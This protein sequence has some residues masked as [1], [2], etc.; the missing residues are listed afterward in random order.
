MNNRDNLLRQLDAFCTFM[1]CTPND[2]IVLTG[3]ALCLDNI[4]DEYRD[5]DLE[6][7]PEVYKKFSELSKTVKDVA[8]ALF[9]VCCSDWSLYKSK[10]KINVYGYN[11]QDP[12]S[13][14]NLKLKTIDK[15][16]EKFCKTD[17]D[18]DKL[19]LANILSSKFEKLKY[20]YEYKNKHYNSNEV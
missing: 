17:I 16:F 12:D 1:N 5:I 7:S 20:A 13:M 8:F 11:I 19:L 9:D 3:A 10:Q 2:F 4:T 15:C 14:I 6:V 18:V